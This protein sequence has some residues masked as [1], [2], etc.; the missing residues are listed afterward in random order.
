MRYLLILGDSLDL[1]ADSVRYGIELARRINAGVTLLVLLENAGAR[2]MKEI[3]EEALARHVAMAAEAG[4]R[5]T[6]VV[7]VGPPRTEV[8]KHLAGEGAPEVAVWA[9]GTGRQADRG[10]WLKQMKE[11]LG[12]PVVVPSARRV[13]RRGRE[14]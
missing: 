4:V 12:C 11:D 7:R 6:A 5:A 2:G 9:G 1:E 13:A 8:I 10:H 14:T 3:A